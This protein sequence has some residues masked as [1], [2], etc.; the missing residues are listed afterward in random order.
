M[1]TIPADTHVAALVL[2]QPIRVRVFE[3]FGIDNIL[4]PRAA[5]L[6]AARQRLPP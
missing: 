1:S 2:E 3:R 5:A 6:E 4:F